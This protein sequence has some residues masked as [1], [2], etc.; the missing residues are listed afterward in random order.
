[1]GM[2]PLCAATTIGCGTCGNNEAC[3]STQTSTTPSCRARINSVPL[4]D[5]IEGTGL[6]ASL[7]FT[8]TG[9]PMIAYYDKIDGALRFAQGDG[10]GGYLLKT[11]DGDDSM[12]PSDVGRH[13]SLAIGPG[14][15]PAIAYMDT[16]RDDL[17]YLDVSYPDGVA[18]QG[19][20]TVTAPARRVTSW[21]PRSSTRRC[22]SGRRGA[23][24]RSSASTAPAGSTPRSCSTR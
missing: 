22:A 23:P 19:T 13:C 4:D 17:V 2:G 5:L 1:F 12:S 7:A 14:D 8:A 20:L 9:T 21:R 6:F 10:R 24:R 3:V 16:T 15:L 11:L 18:A